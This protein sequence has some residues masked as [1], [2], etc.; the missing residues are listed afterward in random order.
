M[1]FCLSGALPDGRFKA[2]IH[3][4]NPLSRSLV[5][6][7][8]TKPAGRS[9]HKGLAF[10][11]P[12]MMPFIQGKILVSEAVFHYVIHYLHYSAFAKH[13]QLLVEL[14]SNPIWEA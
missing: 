3:T 10:S 14:F 1:S 8:S 6:T 13:V 4:H 2:Q 7:P 9:H 5:S 12:K 11:T